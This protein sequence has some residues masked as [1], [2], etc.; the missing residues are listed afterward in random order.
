[1]IPEVERLFAMQLTVGPS[2]GHRG[3]EL[4]SLA[5]AVAP[6]ASVRHR[7]A[8]TARPRE[9]TTHRAEDGSRAQLQ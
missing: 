5:A 7:P 4:L 1:M 3:I 6:G 9:E 8:G 2:L